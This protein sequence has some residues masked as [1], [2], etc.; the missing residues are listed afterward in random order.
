MNNGFR[1]LKEQIEELN[2][3]AHGIVKEIFIC[4][5]EISQALLIVISAIFAFLVAQAQKNLYIY[6]SIISLSFVLFLS[7]K[8]LIYRRNVLTIYHQNLLKE[9]RGG[10]SILRGEISNLQLP[11]N[12]D[13]IKNRRVESI[14]F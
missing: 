8:I 6:A 9:V 2:N 11:N 4:E 10:E 14:Y 12:F 1:E 7:I 3:M 5:R 13:S